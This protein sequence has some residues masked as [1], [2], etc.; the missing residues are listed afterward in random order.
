MVGENEIR[1][2]EVAVAMRPARDSGLVFVG[3]IHTPWTSR[4]ETP[5]QGRLDGPVCQIDLFEPLGPGD[6]RAGGVRAGGGALLAHL[7]RRDLVR[8][9]PADDGTAHGNFLLRSPARP[10]PIGTSIARLV[11]IEG[12]MVLMRGLACIDGTRLH[13]LKP[14]RCLFTPLAPPP[15]GDFEAADGA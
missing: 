11:G 1:A 6:G 8:Q 2:G 12:A 7:S 4:L 13:R 5:R 9:T 10:N 14:D 3:R 15:A